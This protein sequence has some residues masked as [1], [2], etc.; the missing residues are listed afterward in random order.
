MTPWG[1]GMRTIELN[2][3]RAVAALGQ[4]T[5]RIGED[6]ARAAEETHALLTGIDAGMTLIDTA[7]MYGDGATERFSARRCP[8][9][10]RTSFWSARPI[11]GTRRGRNCRSLARRA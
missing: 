4:G 8:V 6:P 5:W 2:G 3:G 7:E 11:R 9:G 1:Y 10:E